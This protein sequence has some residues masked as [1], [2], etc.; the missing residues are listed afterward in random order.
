MPTSGESFRFDAS[1]ASMKSMW[2]ELKFI[3]PQEVMRTP[4]QRISLGDS[5]LGNHRYGQN[6]RLRDVSP[7]VR[8]FGLQVGIVRGL[9]HF[10]TE[11]LLLAETTEGGP[12]QPQDRL[13]IIDLM[14]DFSNSYKTMATLEPGQTYPVGRSHQTEPRA[15]M[16]ATQ[17]PVGRY[18]RDVSRHQFDVVYDQETGP[19]IVNW[20]TKNETVVL[21]SSGDQTMY[22]PEAATTAIPTSEAA[23]R[24]VPQAAHQTQA[25]DL[26]GLRDYFR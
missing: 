4:G 18:G 9:V 24:A 25:I 3:L 20:A 22:S 17:V 8:E 12:R 15:R 23:T 6:R 11:D 14:Q 10:A 16:T 21:Y 19:R 5:V 26:T 13:H 2:G 1:A 7:R